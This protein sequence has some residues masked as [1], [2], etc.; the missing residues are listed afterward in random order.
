VPVRK[1]LARY[2]RR[3]RIATLWGVLGN[4]LAKNWRGVLDDLRDHHQHVVWQ[5]FGK[6]ELKDGV[7]CCLHDDM[8]LLMLS[9]AGRISFM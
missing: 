5:H 3:R 4:P 1:I 2:I 8:Y 6:E 7:F 9:W